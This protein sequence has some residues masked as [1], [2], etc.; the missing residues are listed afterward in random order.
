VKFGL[1]IGISCRPVHKPAQPGGQPI[2]GPEYAGK[3]ARTGITGTGGISIRPPS[4]D[5][6]MSKLYM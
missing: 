6:A 4:F 2:A 5:G 1:R 3:P